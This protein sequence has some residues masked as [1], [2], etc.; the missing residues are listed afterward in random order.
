MKKKIKFILLGFTLVSCFI[1]YHLLII[2]HS[3]KFVFEETIYWKNAT[4]HRASGVGYK[5][6]RTV[7]MAGNHSISLVKGDKSR[8][9]IFVSSPLI[10]SD[11][12]VRGD[13]IIPRYGQ[14]TAVFWDYY[15]IT[16][17]EFINAISEICQNNENSFEYHG[18]GLFILSETQ[19]MKRVYLQYENC[20]VATDY[21]GF[22]GKLNDNW[23]M[24]NEGRNT[25]GVYTVFC[26]IIPSS[27]ISILE[28]YF[29]LII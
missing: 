21:V 29:K 12:Y 18:E 20:P 8:S 17:I 27:Y 28:K 6:G 25:D 1:L 5:V 23:V 3:A 9:F 24:A 2:D 15:K 13:Y 22:I 10:G 4:Y 19:R 7:A 11:L 16:D 26:R 14:I